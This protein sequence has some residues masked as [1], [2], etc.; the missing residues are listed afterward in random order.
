MPVM[1]I[2]GT[3]VVTDSPDTLT[4]PETTV[5]PAPAVTVPVM[6]T[7]VAVVDCPPA[8]QTTNPVALID[9]TAVVADSPETVTVPETT[10]DTDRPGTTETICVP[11]MV[12]MVLMVGMTDT[13][14]DV[15]AIVTTC[16]PSCVTTVLR[17]L[18]VPSVCPTPSQTIG[19]VTP[20]VAVVV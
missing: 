7:G 5:V 3:A 9:G 1:L 16:V 2:E 20:E 14:T 6:T 4:V 19:P 10:A 11:R 12:V 8:S 17:T 15:C 13:L 18:T